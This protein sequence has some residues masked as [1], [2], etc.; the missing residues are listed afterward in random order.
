MNETTA[1]LTSN[2]LTYFHLLNNKYTKP[3][4]V[5]PQNL[6]IGAYMDACLSGDI[7]HVIHVQNLDS[8]ECPD[9]E[10][11]KQ[12]EEFFNEQVEA[13]KHPRGER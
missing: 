7:D 5:D 2:F 10:A 4:P 13:Y 9:H 6:A 8:P 12:A 1:T 3:Y 11:A